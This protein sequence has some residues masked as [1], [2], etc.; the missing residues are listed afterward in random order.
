[1]DHNAY[2]HKHPGE[3]RKRGKYGKPCDV[4]STRRIRCVSLPNSTKCTG[5]TSQNRECTNSRIRKKLGPRPA[6]KDT[7]AKPEAET[8]FD[9]VEQLSLFA[10]SPLRLTPRFISLGTQ[11]HLPGNEAPQFASRLAYNPR[12]APSL[13]YLALLNAPVFTHGVPLDGSPFDLENGPGLQP[14]K[15]QDGA[16]P[17]APFNPSRRNTHSGSK[18]AFTGAFGGTHGAKEDR[19]KR[20]NTSADDKGGMLAQ[21]PTFPV[22][23]P[24][25]PPQYAS[26][27]IDKLLP[28]LQVYQTWFYGYWPVLSVADLMLTLV[29]NSEMDELSSYFLLTERNAMSYALC[30][31]VCATILT[32]MTFVMSR[33]KLLSVHT[34]LPAELYAEDAKRVRHLFDY[35]ES[36]DVT[37]LLSSFFLYTHYVNIKG[38]TAQAILYLREAITTCQ[39]LGLHEPS[40]YVCKSAAEVHRCKKIY[41][42]LLVTERFMCFEDG[43]PVILDPVIALPSLQNEEYPS[44]L[45]GFTE[46]VRV[47][48]VPS[49]GFFGELNQKKGNLE[50]TAFRHTPD[51]EGLEDKKSWVMNVYQ[52]LRQPLSDAIQV[53][54]SQKLNIALSRAWIQAIA[55]HITSEN[56]LISRKANALNCF[57][58]N[59]PLVIVDDFLKSVENLPLFAFESNG[60]GICVKLLAVASSLNRALLHE[61]ANR[62]LCDRLNTLFTLIT[63]YKNDV[64]LPMDIYTSIAATIVNQKNHVPRPLALSDYELGKVEEILDTDDKTDLMLDEQG[65]MGHAGQLG[66]AGQMGQM[67]SSLQLLCMYKDVAITPSG[68][69]FAGITLNPHTHAPGDFDALNKSKSSSALSIIEMMHAFVQ[70][71]HTQNK[72]DAYP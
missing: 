36:P 61:P 2:P 48:A 28:C 49:K 29:D 17:G 21:T 25:L 54:D 16:A 32:Q 66:Q 33:F 35:T 41:Y 69:P 62:I 11:D 26:I 1:M 34:Y 18:S 71:P 46:L 40:T 59:F 51:K 63:R 60:P 52:K 19:P 44:L 31:A 42:M 38:K 58:V 53:S 12:V 30:C 13:G 39:L 27:P 45:V 37:T 57:S 56:G 64:S 23:S 20:R 9:R 14:A 65:L 6:Q 24:E 15:P 4:C 47:F 5:C 43:L 10:D 3:P 67:G 68:D 55:W 22:C 8:P 7:T 70:D 50:L 72:S